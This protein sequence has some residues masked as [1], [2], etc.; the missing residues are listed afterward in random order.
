[1]S[2]YTLGLCLIL[3]LM[4]GLLLFAVAV[5]AVF[6]PH[7]GLFKWIARK[8]YGGGLWGCAIVIALM[9]GSKGTRQ[10]EIRRCR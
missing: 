4:V 3:P 9:F 1:M 7:R 6:L 8:L 5:A 2:R 10:E